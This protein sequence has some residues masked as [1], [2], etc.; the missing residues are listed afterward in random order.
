MRPFFVKHLLFA[1]GILIFNANLASASIPSLDALKMRLH[2]ARAGAHQGGFFFG[3][4]PNTLRNFESARS[5]G[6]DVVEMDLHLSK[7]GVPVVYHDDT[8]DLWTHC[9]GKVHDKTLEEL[10]ACRFKFSKSSIPTYEEILVWSQGRVV[11]NAEFKD[12]ESIEPAIRVVQKY[13]AYSWTYFQTKKS[14]ERYNQAHNFDPKIALL[15]VISGSD[16]L[17]WA[18]SQ[19]EALVLIELHKETRLPQFIDAI[20]ASGRLVTENAWHLGSPYELFS[21]SCR[22]MFDLGID[23]V[24]SNRPKGCVKQRNEFIAGLPAQEY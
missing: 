8:L 21:A 6:V 13:D 19:D 4:W 23:I 11:V 24:I 15:Y 17:N 16:D 9:K 22:L 5:S 18:L 1:G 3:H 10:K 2:G 14:R 12:F 20:H 7:D